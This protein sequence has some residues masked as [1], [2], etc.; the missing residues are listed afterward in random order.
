[1]FLAGDT[2]KCAMPGNC[3]SAGPLGRV[4]RVRGE[5][6]RPTSHPGPHPEERAPATKGVNGDGSKLALG[7]SLAAIHFRLA[8][9]AGLDKS[10]H[11][12]VRQM[13]AVPVHARS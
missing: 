11:A 5:A 9:L 2:P 3:G 1:M 6:L 13:S 7:L 12:G 8:D 4:P 10:V